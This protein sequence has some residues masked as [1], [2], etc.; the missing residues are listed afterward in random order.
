[1]NE[2]A[3][4]GGF[5]DDRLLA[6]ALGLSDDP[7]LVS[8][9]AG[10]A[11]LGRRLEAMR[12]DVRAVGEG[13]N[14]AVPA[15]DDS[16]ADLS[17]ERWRR[18][19][20]YLRVARPGRPARRPRVFLRRA[21]A[22]AAA[23]LVVAAI[24]G[25]VL[26]LTHHGKSSSSTSTLAAKG[27]SVRAPEAAPGAATGAVPM[28]QA[29]PT[30]QLAAAYDTV[31]VARAGQ[32]GGSQQRFTVLR[33]LKGTAPKRLRLRR[34]GGSL[35]PRTLAILYLRPSAGAAVPAG[36]LGLLG[37]GPA[38]DAGIAGTSTPTPQPA[39]SAMMRPIPAPGSSAD[40]GEVGFGSAAGTTYTFRHS[41]VLVVPL[42]AGTKADTIRL[43]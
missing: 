42:P 3:A 34:E 23:L 10:D 24:L 20:P 21:L 32:V 22:P 1:M 41:E 13:V 28:T 5:D 26:A 14:T 17:Q 29:V 43:P 15:P 4:G 11:E 37:G 40:G 27:N 19:A 2:L 18:L 25:G 30:R 35:A 31:V 9:A 39:G 12:A 16:Y 38:H 33:T 6:F 8:A 36:A 7:E